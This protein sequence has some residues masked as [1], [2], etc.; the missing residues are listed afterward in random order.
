MS[1]L[2]NETP[3][4][5]YNQD[6]NIKAFE[7]MPAK[8]VG[9]KIHASTLDELT[10]QLPQGFYTTFGTLSGG[11]RVLGLKA[12]L[13]RLYGP[14][15]DL[16]LHVPLE[17][18]SLRT[19]IAQ[20]VK[21]NLPH[22]S[23]VR[24]LL[25]RDQGRLYIAVQTFEPLPK[26]VYRDGVKVITSETARQDPRI[27]DTG[28]ISASAAQRK[29]L[30]SEVFEILLV[31]NGKILE[32]MTSNFY[33]VKGSTLVTAQRGI[34]L[35]VTRKAVLR[36]ARGQGMSI[37]YR[38]PS[39]TEKFDEAFLTSSSR[40]VVPIVSLDQKPIGQGNVGKWAKVLSQAYQAYV[41]ERSEKIIR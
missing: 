41:Q 18:T 39:F 25:T 36:L 19:R 24:L 23:R 32:G 15:R 9:L 10:N 22:E 4:R 30:S 17:E 31:Q 11:T 28:F 5:D 33:A 27:K 16:H 34:L 40:G 20:V 37:A 14:A 6:M 2:I 1:L 26:S 8:N 12:H 35:G 3:P 21:E 38:A 13:Q 29:L 7:I